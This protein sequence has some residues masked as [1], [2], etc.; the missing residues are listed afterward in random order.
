MSFLWTIRAV[1]LLVILPR[2]S[3]VVLRYYLYLHFVHS[4]S[5]ILYFKRHGF[6]QKL[7]A[8]APCLCDSLRS[9]HCSYITFHGCIRQRTYCDCPNIFSAPLRVLDIPQRA[10]KRRSSCSPVSRSCKFA[11]NGKGQRDGPSFR[12]FGPLQRRFTYH[13]C[14]SPIHSS[15]GLP[16]SSLCVVRSQPGT[17]AAIYGAT[18]AAFPK[19][20]FVTSAALLYIAVSLLARIRPNIHNPPTEPEGTDT[21]Q[22]SEEVEDAGEGSYRS[23]SRSHD[24]VPENE[25]ENEE[26]QAS[27]I[28]L[29]APGD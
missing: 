28:L 29:S 27:V 21:V 20:M 16:H 5:C 22:A 18:V 6:D 9:A 23:R 13:R 8:R 14:S 7:N 3:L 4:Y 17:Y 2:K 12:C 15:L 10:Y 19:A 26:L 11:C 25:P 1:N 24:D